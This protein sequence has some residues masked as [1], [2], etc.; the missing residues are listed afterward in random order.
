[1]NKKILIINSSAFT[2]GDIAIS[3]CMIDQILKVIP[4]AKIT[5]ES[6]NASVH[7][8][9]VNKK[10][11]QIVQRLFDTRRIAVFPRSYM[12]L[13]FLI[14]N[15]SVIFEY[16]FDALELTLFCIFKKSI[17][18]REIYKVINDSD[19]IIG[20]GGDAITKNYGFF[21][22]L[23]TF[24]LLRIMNK[25]IL[26]YASTIGPFSGISKFFTAKCLK[27]LDLIMV[28]DKKS[29]NFLIEIG[30]RPTSV[31]Q[32][33]DCVI[34]LKQKK[35]LKTRKAIKN[36]KITKQS[37]GIFLRNNTFSNVLNKQYLKY[38]KSITKIASKLVSLNHSVIFFS[39][40]NT[41]Y[42][43]TKSF[44][45]GYKLDYPA[46]NMMDY[47]PYEAKELLSK[48]GLIISSRMHPIILASTAGVPV[49]GISDE[50]KMFEYLQLINIPEF[51]LK[52]S[53]FKVSS[54][55]HLIT[56]IFKNRNSVITNNLKDY[57]VGAKILANRNL[58]Y[59]K[60]WFSEEKC[61]IN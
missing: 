60:K 46:V 8:K 19:I 29:Y 7:K 24:L 38:L 21:L 20:A 44:L 33:A 17:S 10:G 15:L 3:N 27:K 14:K 37:V 12:S 42:D 6:G 43:I 45:N 57:V 39:A 61:K 32:T 47:K 18:K 28:R 26:I 35:T 2:I 48:M 22:R 13:P 55:M 41:D 56:D 34:L 16:F 53:D 58:T 31:K 23:Y 5:V 59:L 40:N 50:P 11:I 25:K 1:M 4:E 52:L 49:I 51:Y 54:T 36:L 9:F 30:L